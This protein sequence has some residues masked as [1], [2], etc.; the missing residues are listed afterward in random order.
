MNQD[1]SSSEFRAKRD[2]QEVKDRA[3]QIRELFRR[4]SITFHAT[5]AIEELLKDA[6][7]LEGNFI[8]GKSG[9]SEFQILLNAAHLDRMV[10]ALL[11][12]EGDSNCRAYL[13]KLT[14]ASLNFL[15]RTPSHAKDIFW[16]IELWAILKRN[17][18]NVRLV[19]PPDIIIDTDDGPLAIAC[20]KI[21]SRKNVA[22]QLSSAVKQL[23]LFG[24]IGIA[25]INIDDLVPGDS[26]LRS[27]TSA[28]MLKFIDAENIRFLSSFERP[29]RSYFENGRLSAVAICTSLLAEVTNDGTRFNNAK[30]MT[31]WA[32][33]GV[34]AVVANRVK[35]FAKTMGIPIEYK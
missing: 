22:R 18:P 14:S 34:P 20:K 21:Y 27:R 15:G 32:W 8:A 26:L 5:S 33:P 35:Y 6:E 10:D 23:K 30:Q 2:Y 4:Q 16:E 11:L 29:I 17:D 9:A 19:D 13:N 24:G 1:C 3:L 7:A 12:L 31:I 28:E 25:A